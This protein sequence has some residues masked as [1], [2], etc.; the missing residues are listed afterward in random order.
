MRWCFLSFDDLALNTNGSA[1]LT[2]LGWD[3]TAGSAGLVD[4][5]GSTGGASAFSSAGAGPAVA[6]MTVDFVK[7]APTWA[8]GVTAHF[9]PV[10]GFPAANASPPVGDTVASVFGNAFR[11]AAE[12]PVG[13]LSRAKPA[14]RLVPGN[15]SS[16]AARIGKRS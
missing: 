9:T 16:A 13:T 4:F 7:Q 6:T 12:A 14:R 10:P 2:F 8:S 3:Q 15:T 1:T 5:L 11:D